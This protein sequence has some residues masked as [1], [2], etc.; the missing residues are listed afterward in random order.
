M[1]DSALDLSELSCRT[2]GD[3]TMYAVSTVTD[4][5]LV[6]GGVIDDAARCAFT[7][8]QCH[9]LA[10]ALW[11][12]T[13]WPI[14]ALVAPVDGA[15][16]E[17]VNSTISTTDDTPTINAYGLSSFADHLAVRHPS[18]QLLDIL[19][20]A[21][22]VQVMGRYGHRR[23]PIDDQWGLLPQQHPDWHL[24]CTEDGAADPEELDAL[25]EDALWD[26]DCRLV[27]VDPEHVH[28]LFGRRAAIE[29]ARTL[30]APLLD[31]LP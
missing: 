4:A 10:F 11:E 15:S 1:P 14:V 23:A 5:I 6:T 18:G 7:Q 25:A 2:V 29:A 27:A 16:G 13:E 12:R 9:A 30:V 3:H 8:G 17:M 22:L 24:V 26:Y 28:G 21:D 19:G 31:Q 20:L